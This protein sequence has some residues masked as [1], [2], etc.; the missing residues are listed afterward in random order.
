ME[1]MYDTPDQ[2]MA[3]VPSG[4]PVSF[5]VEDT[6]SVPSFEAATDFAPAKVQVYHDAP[7]VANDDSTVP[8]LDFELPTIRP[9][10]EIVRDMLAELS[11]TERVGHF[12]RFVVARLDAIRVAAPANAGD[13]FANEPTHVP[14]VDYVSRIV[15]LTKVFPNCILAGLVYIERMIEKN[16]ALQISEA[17][18]HRL[19]FMAT[20]LASKFLHDIPLQNKYWSKIS[21][22][23][24]LTEVNTMEREIL[25]L[26]GYDL[27]I[28]EDVFGDLA[29]AALA[30]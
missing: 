28:N 24:S 25:T 12:A 11:H 19:V 26:L 13:K 1:F 5:K 30:Y 27:N 22:T 10:H 21:G 15:K 29:C 17:N 16:P 18:A 4:S 6:S 9:R 23:Y 20:L 2:M 8:D 7:V 3:E 14:L